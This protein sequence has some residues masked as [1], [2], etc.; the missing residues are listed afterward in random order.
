MEDGGYRENMT[1][2]KLV[3]IGN[4]MAGM[5]CI[6]ELL[7]I[8]D[9]L[10]DITVFGSEPYPNYNRIM[11]SKVLQGNF[12]MDEITIH[13]F[14]WYDEMGI[15]LYTDTTITSINIKDKFV[16]SSK[17]FKQ[18]YDRLILATGS[19]A[20]IPK[21]PGVD[22][23]GVTG[24]RSIQDCLAMIEAS[25]RY[26]R[27]AVI[28]GGLLGLE[29]AKGLLNLGM[30]V[31]VVHNASYI[32]NRQLDSVSA[33]LLRKE[34]EAQGMRFLLNKRTEKVFGHGR[35]KG[36]MFDDGTKLVADYIVFAVGIKPRIEFAANSGIDTNRAF[37]V[38]DY[39]Q[40]N[41][42]D[43]Y[44]VGE[45]A[46]HQGI[47]YGLVAPLYEQGKVLARTLC[48]VETEPYTGTV[49][50]AQL[51]ISGVDVFSA[52]N[53]YEASQEATAQQMY[54][55][56]KGSYKRVL[57]TKGKVSG[58]ILYGD[59][60]DSTHLL[61]LIQKEAPVAELYQEPSTG[62]RDEAAAALAPKDT[63]CACN[64]V[65]KLDIVTV[66]C[67]D[68]LETV[69]EVRDKT[70]A[71]GSCGGCRPLVEAIIKLT[72]E[73][74][75]QLEPEIPEP[76]CG[77]SELD[78]QSLREEIASELTQEPR[79]MMSRLAWKQPNGC[80]IC[81]GA[82][83]YYWE[84]HN[85]SYSDHQAFKGM[86]I[87]KRALGAS[88]QL[89]CEPSVE[90]NSISAQAIWLKQQFEA[91]FASLPM[92]SAIS[93]AVSGGTSFPAGVFVS[94]IGLTSTPAGWE[95]YV[96]GHAELP[97]QQGK[98]L[99]IEET[100]ASALDITICSVQWYRETA[101]FGEPVWEWVERL[102]ITIIREKLLN[103]QQRKQL[104][105]RWQKHQTR[106]A[107]TATISTDAVKL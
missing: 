88:I 67:R 101:Y 81:Q 22:K 102:G 47:V 52:G 20:F 63:V 70:K 103:P 2:K 14:S 16:V 64:G 5:R 48:G 87:K 73:S 99:S 84:V 34:L 30:D 72:L 23:S 80:A 96:G 90:R 1:R 75:P 69:E 15:K 92:P 28:G 98:L 79:E 9:S 21:L 74:P 11:L 3:V 95:I 65:C 53:V 7:K 10:Y 91:S 35:A 58:A 45:C 86:K 8:D 97:L 12:S 89:A 105:K 66:V 51:K 85:K 25:K 93:I 43:V 56:V 24:F 68:G 94:S 83:G 37:V 61:N 38:D 40:T 36:L 26:K 18:S 32:M 44:A 57:M 13:P 50:S 54:D 41:I 107:L 49:S 42:P 100:V 6:E 104:Y 33:E 71:S 39:M 76:I 59:I 17:G 62:A 77:C 31:H 55:A 78:H 19:S 46:E 106:S 29:A 27:A 82:I 4:G 60:G